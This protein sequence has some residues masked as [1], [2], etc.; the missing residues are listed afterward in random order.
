MSA[1]NAPCLHGRSARAFSC[2][3]REQ[4]FADC[5]TTDVSCNEGL[6]DDTSMFAERNASM[7]RYSGYKP[8]NESS[9]LKHWRIHEHFG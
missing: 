9:G 4:Q 7:S 2:H 8:D 5:D 6:M 3:L 1:P